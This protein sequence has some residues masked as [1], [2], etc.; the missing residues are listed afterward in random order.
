MKIELNETD[1]AKCPDRLLGELLTAILGRPGPVEN[2][3]PASKPAPVDDSTGDDPEPPSPEKKPK[4]GRPSKSTPKTDPVD[5][6]TGDDP[7]AGPLSR[8]DLYGYL[9]GFV[10]KHGKGPVKALLKN[11]GAE[12]LV[13]L[14]ADQYSEDRK[15]VV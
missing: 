11:L 3:K 6:S 14:K 1:L 13:D 7:E 15:S 9:S 8:E 4:R 12:K 10:E 2:V 5:D